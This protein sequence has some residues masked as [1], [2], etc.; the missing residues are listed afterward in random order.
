MVRDKIFAV[1]GSQF[2]NDQ[3]QKSLDSFEATAAKN[4]IELGKP[5]GAER[6]LKSVEGKA[7]R[8]ARK[9]LYLNN[10]VRN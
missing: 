2:T 6:L 7:R 8:Q 1:L 9:I 5:K 3:V 10:S 4:L